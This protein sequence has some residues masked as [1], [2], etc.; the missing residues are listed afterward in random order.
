MPSHTRPALTVSIVF[1]LHEQPAS[2]VF[3]MTSDISF[4]LEAYYSP[5]DWHNLVDACICKKPTKTVVR[6]ESHSTESKI[7]VKSGK[8][9]F[10]AKTKTIG[11]TSY[12]HIE[13]PTAKCVESFRE[14]AR[15]TEDWLK[16]KN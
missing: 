4:G 5:S 14:A 11:Y 3:R 12:T 2:V 10:R 15:L 1:P 16:C 7:V 6:S 13:Y 9:I 8:V